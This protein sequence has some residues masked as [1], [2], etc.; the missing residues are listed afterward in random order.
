VR[1]GFG[2]AS[3]L[4]LED[5]DAIAD[6]ANVPSAAAVAPEYA[7]GTQVM[8][9]DT[10]TNVQ[11]IGTTGAYA[12]VFELSTASGRFVDADDVDRRAAVAVLGS[13]VADDLFGGFDPV[14]QRVKVALPGG[15]GGR[16]SLTVVGVLMPVGGSFLADAD[17]SVYVPIS[18]AQFKLFEGRNPLGDAVVSRINVEAL[19]EADAASAQ[20]EITA[21]LSDRHRIGDDEEPDFEVMSQSEMLAMADEVT[22]VLSVFLGAIAGISLVVGGIGIMNIMLVS[23]TERTREVGLRKAL[24]ARRSDILV[25]F[26]LESVV[27][28]ALGGVVGVAVGIAAAKVVDLSGVMRAAVSTTSVL[29]ALGASLGVGLFF[30]IYPANR[31]ARLSPIEALRHE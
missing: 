16:V 17:D 28:S 29:L 24:G 1:G 8:F 6:P 18:T 13:Q 11:V 7:R 15:D 3:T 22:G 12:D 9:G 23:V 2:S 5:A 10:N 4:T 27:L 20:A 21:L 26:L 19:S 14:G 30:G 25:Q 31:A